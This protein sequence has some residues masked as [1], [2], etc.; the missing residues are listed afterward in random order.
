MEKVRSQCTGKLQNITTPNPQSGPDLQT[1]Y[2]YDK[3]G[4]LIGVTMP[5]LDGIRSES[6]FPRPTTCKE[7]SLIRKAGRKFASLMTMARSPRRPIISVNVSLIHMTIKNVAYRCKG[8][9]Q[10]DRFSL[11]NVSAIPM[12]PIHMIRYFPRTAKDKLAAMQ[13]GSPDVLPGLMTEMYSYDSSGRRIAKR[14]RINRGGIN[15]DLD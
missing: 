14:F 12:I 8:S 4:K 6:F 10:P 7:P 1:Q 5:R 9:T 13:W 15:L 3:M 2:R 11:R